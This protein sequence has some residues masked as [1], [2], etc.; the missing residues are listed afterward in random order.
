MGRSEN[1]GDFAGGSVDVKRAG[2]GGQLPHGGQV[3]GGG[4]G[5]LRAEI[6]LLHGGDLAAHPAQGKAALLCLAGVEMVSEALVEM[7]RRALSQEQICV[8][9]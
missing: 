8:K 5:G 6:A 3:D 1:C 4:R 7:E 2:V 9:I